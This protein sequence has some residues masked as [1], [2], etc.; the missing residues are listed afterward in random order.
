MVFFLKI[1]GGKFN[2]GRD[3][4]GK[5]FLYDRKVPDRTSWEHNQSYY[6]GKIA[7]LLDMKVENKD[8]EF[9][10][11]EQEKQNV[12]NLL[13]KIGI[14]NNDFVVGINPGGDRKT[15]QW[16]PEKFAFVA[17]YLIKNYSSKILI[18]GAEEERPL[19]EE[20]FS[21]MT[22]GKPH[23]LCGKTNISELIL[24]IKRC[25]IVVST[26][27]AAMHIAGLVGT[28]VVGLIGPG[29]PF[30]DRPTG[31]DDKIKLLYKK[32]D[33]NP[34]YHWECKR[35]EKICMTKILPE[36]VIKAVEELIK[37]NRNG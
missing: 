29:N 32:V 22:N 14:K 12:L 25:N 6:F 5:G 35:K 26:N 31:D 16:F 33:C 11:S 3:T 15:R 18:F 13:D 37:L 7:E 24:L 4:D 20:I 34:C 10:H 30:R 21:K 2:I 8:V 27:S 28:P 23:I 17:D 9:W 36:E 19:A 1:I